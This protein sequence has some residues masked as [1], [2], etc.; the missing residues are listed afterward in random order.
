VRDT[1]IREEFDGDLYRG[2]LVKWSDTL[3]SYFD[4]VWR[5]L[6]PDDQLLLGDRI[7]LITDDTDFV[8]TYFQTDERLVWGK[9]IS[10][11]SPKG[12]VCI[13]YYNWSKEELENLIVEFIKGSIAHEL[14]HVYLGHVYM[15][16]PE[17]TKEYEKY[18][19]EADSQVKKWGFMPPFI[20]QRKRA[21]ERKYK[22]S[23]NRNGINE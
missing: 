10:V 9:A 23:D 3:K 12:F 22:A 15:T 8:D 16:P 17:S 18:E 2:M 6:P 19:L 11:P 1:I 21:L 4:E 20:E 7:T 14:A 13:I 5:K